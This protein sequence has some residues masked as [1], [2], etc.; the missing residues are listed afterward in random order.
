MIVFPAIDIRGG[1]C[2]RL[3]QGRFDQQTV[4]AEDPERV[5]D[6]FIDKGASW[7]HVVDLDGARTGDAKNLEIIER[8]AKKNVNVELGGG[9]R[10]LADIQRRIDAG[11]SRCIIGT[12]ALEHPQ[13][14]RDAVVRFGDCIAVGIDARDGLV[15]TH[16]W[17]Q[18][19]Q[20]SALDFAMQMKQ[21]GVETVI[22]TDISKDGMQ[23]GPNLSASLV[24]Q[25]ETGLHV[26]VSGG[27]SSLADVQAVKEQNLYGVITGKAIYDGNLDIAAAL[28]LSD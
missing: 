2:V 1:K 25:K 11:V 14:V 9:I 16:G 7:L 12:A 8:I 13:M 15:A 26:I 28:A 24:L 19:S 22:H 3:T 18:V 4:Y 5:A 23:S 27:I 20:K 21:M 6:A 17:E 10:S